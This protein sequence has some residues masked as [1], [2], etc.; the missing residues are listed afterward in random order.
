MSLLQRMLIILTTESISVKTLW[1]CHSVCSGSHIYQWKAYGGWLN[2]S[3]PSQSHT[4]VHIYISSVQ[5]G[6]STLLKH[7]LPHYV[8]ISSWI[9][10]HDLP[11]SPGELTRIFSLQYPSGI[12]SHSSKNHRGVSWLSII[13]LISLFRGVHQVLGSQ[14]LKLHQPR[15]WV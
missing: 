15:P 9:V 2:S 4:Y 11:F 5:T 6:S 14:L 13:R 8:S 12:M 1:L 7:F 3:F 10:F